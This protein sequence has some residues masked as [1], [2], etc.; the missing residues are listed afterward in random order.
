MTL[1]PS[2]CAPSTVAVR[3]LPVMA[4]NFSA[5]SGCSF[6][7]S[8]RFM[9]AAASGCSLFASSET[10]ACKSSRSVTPSAGMRS[11]TSGWPEVM[12]PVLSRATMRVRPVCSRLA[13]VLNRMP[14]FAPTPLPT[15]MATGVAR[16]SA[17]GQLMTS[18]EMPRASAKEN[19]RPSSSQT[20]VVTSAME[21]T[22]GTN[23]PATLSAVL[24]IGAFVAA[25]SETMRMIWLSVVSS[26]TRVASQRR[27]PEQ[28]TVAAETPSPGALS[29]GTLS[30][31]SAASLTA[32]APS[33]TTPST[34]MLWP[35]RTTNT[36]PLRTCAAGILT[37]LPSRMTVAVSGARAMRLLSASVVLP[38]EC[39]SSSLPTV[40]SVRI[41]AADSK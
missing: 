11:V 7:S 12:V 9:I 28:L 36:S 40:M 37:S 14:F 16:P 23:T 38:L 35:G 24:A 5:A 13:A 10:A 21:M 26:P 3:P 25:A 4:A 29:T 27:K 32:L 33:S 31:V 15:M 19:S 6:S 30:P 34:G 20:I 18:T 41:M 1:P 22:A 17:H 2:S 39:A 8:P